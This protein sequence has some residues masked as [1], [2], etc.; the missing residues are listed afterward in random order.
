M[1]G[2]SMFG[3]RS[4]SADRRKKHRA[5]RRASNKHWLKVERK[6]ILGKKVLWVLAENEL[7]GDVVVAERDYRSKSP[8]RSHKP[9]E[10]PPVMAENQL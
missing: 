1:E 3:L 6:S 7:S 5:M 9:V 2:V 10:M 4:L 8:R